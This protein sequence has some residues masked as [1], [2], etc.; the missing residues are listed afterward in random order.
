MESLFAFAPLLACPLMLLMGG[1]VARALKR[2]GQRTANDH[3]A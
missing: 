1:G 3:Q 2:R